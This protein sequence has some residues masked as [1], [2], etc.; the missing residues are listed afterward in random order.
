MGDIKSTK[1]GAN[2]IKRYFIIDDLRLNCNLR[3]P[4]QFKVVVLGQHRKI[5]S[6]SGKLG[7]SF[8]FS[9]AKLTS[10]ENMEREC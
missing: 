8:L 5:I 4:K 9:S 6:R 1:I 2:K 7:Y 3:N 10:L